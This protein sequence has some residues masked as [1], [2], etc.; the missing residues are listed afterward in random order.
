LWNREAIRKLKDMEL[1]PYQ[2]N[3][4]KITNLSE[5]WKIGAVIKVAN[6]EIMRY[7][8]KYMINQEIQ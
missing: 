6:R 8:M 1:I 2:K 7:M 3:K 4:R 5:Y